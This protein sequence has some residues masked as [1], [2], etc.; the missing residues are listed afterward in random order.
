MAPNSFFPL[1]G[2]RGGRGGAQLG[3]SNICSIIISIIASI[4]RIIAA[5]VMPW[6]VLSLL[7]LPG[8]IVVG[9]AAS[10]PAALPS[11]SPR[12]FS[13][14]KDALVVSRMT[15]G[16][17]A[18]GRPGC[19]L[20]ALHGGTACVAQAVWHSPRDLD[21]DGGSRRRLCGCTCYRAHQYFRCC[22]DWAGCMATVVGLHWARW[23]SPCACCLHA[24]RGWF[25]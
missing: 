3:S 6:C 7:L 12:E 8:R 14:P 20:L 13:H 9:A 18:C 15:C 22:V 16:V 2:V 24:A 19:D 10:I 25:G 23:A 11:S 17:C 1:L 4:M 5:G 21:G